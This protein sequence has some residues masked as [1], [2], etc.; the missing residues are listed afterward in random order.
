MTK[1][2][3]IELFFS[4]VSMSTENQIYIDLETTG[5][6][7][8][9]CQIVQVGMATD[10]KE[11]SKKC[12]LNDDT[13]AQ[14]EKELDSGVVLD[15]SSMHWV[16]AFNSYDTKFISFSNTINAHGRP[17][18][19]PNR[20]TKE[21]FNDFKQ[22][23]YPLPCE[24]SLLR[25][26]K[27]FMAEA[28]EVKESVVVGHNIVRYDLPFFASRYEAYDMPSFSYGKVVDTMWLSRLHLLPAIELLA[29]IGNESSLR[30]SEKLKTPKGLSSK[31]QDLALAFGVEE[32]L[33]HD[34]LGDVKT[35][36]AV[37]TKVVAFMDENRTDIINLGVKVREASDKA[38]AK[39]AK[40]NYKY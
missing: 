24:K 22:A 6:D 32:G 30:L 39:Y 23:Q 35:N 37:Y 38:H 15:T 40:R 8:H 27:R 9:K 2:E 31:L 5:L 1:S 11:F 13:M 16:L 19:V 4:G 33:A 36:R 7:K 29:E 20:M 14:L 3:V 34:A 28:M 18:N 25:K 17:Y 21:A 12:R 10:T 26:A